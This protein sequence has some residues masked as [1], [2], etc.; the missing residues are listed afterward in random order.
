MGDLQQLL[1]CFVTTKRK[2]IGN[3][4]L[5]L[6]ESAFCWRLARRKCRISEIES[7]RS[8]CHAR[9]SITKITGQDVGCRQSLSTN[10]FSGFL[11]V[12]KNL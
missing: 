10:G 2:L 9:L 3:V 12:V 11:I 7:K 4:I 5:K 1:P 8:S 6:T